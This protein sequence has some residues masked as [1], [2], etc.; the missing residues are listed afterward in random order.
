MSNQSN[1]QNAWVCCSSCQRV[2]SVLF[3]MSATEQICVIHKCFVGW[4]WPVQSGFV[5]GRWPVQSGFVGWRGKASSKISEN[6]RCNLRETV[7]SSF[8]YRLMNCKERHQSNNILL[9]NS[10]WAKEKNGVFIFGM[11]S[12]IRRSNQGKFG[13]ELNCKSLGGNVG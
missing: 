11:P 12:I 6:Y 4:R 7:R 5:R 10:T 1:I 9:I 2:S 3:K 8:N 13:V